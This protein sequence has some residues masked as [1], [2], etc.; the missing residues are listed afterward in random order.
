MKDKE[1]LK[2]GWDEVAKLRQELETNEIAKA[3]MGE[4]I[5]NIAMQLDSTRAELE[6]RKFDAEYA[7]ASFIKQIERLEK[8]YNDALQ[9]RDRLET[10][11]QT[12]Q[13]KFEQHTRADRAVVDHPAVVNPRNGDKVTKTNEVDIAMILEQNQTLKRRNSSLCTQIAALS[14]APGQRREDAYYTQ[15]L[16]MLNQMIQGWV[17]RVFKGQ[18]VLEL[19]EE[20]ELYV[21]AIL[22]DPALRPHGTKTAELLSLGR[23]GTIRTIFQN[24]RRRMVLVRHIVALFLW[25]YVFDRFVFGLS[26]RQRDFDQDSLTDFSK[27]LKGIS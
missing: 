26:V 16:N 2:S 19:S 18:S 23:F 17:A 20:S 13:S 9:H 10:E 27:S 5:K 14:S 22:K 25:G 24:S 12:T 6:Q 21:L 4:A 8:A 7:K 1:T 15:P 3:G 11:L